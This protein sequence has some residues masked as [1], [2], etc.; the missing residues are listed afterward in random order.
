MFKANITQTPFTTDAANACFP[1]ITGDKFGYDVTF[2]A[3]LRAL[4][5]PRMNDRESIYL[6][7]GSSNHSYSAVRGS[8]DEAVVS[9]ICGGYRLNSPGQLVIHSIKGAHGQREVEENKKDIEANFKSIESGFTSAYRGYHRSDGL[10]AFYRKSFLVDCYINPELKS[11]I[12]FVENLDN[13]K[14]H[15]LQVSI[16]AMLSWYLDPKAGLSKDE[17]ELVYSL[18]ETTP[19]KYNQCLAKMA[20]NYDFRTAKIRQMLSD[21]ETKYEKAECEKVK[22]EIESYDNHIRD[23]NH[24]I[25]D[26]LRQ[27]NESCIRLMGLQ[28][29]IAQGGDS[30][31]MEYF[32]C[33]RHLVPER[34]TTSDMFFAVKD[35]LEYF[36]S[37]MAES[38]IENE[39]SFVY[40]YGLASTSEEGAK[41]AERLMKEIFVSD[42]PRLRIRFCAAYQFGLN[43]SVEA[44]RD[45]GFGIEFD[46]YMPNPHINRYRCLGGY[47]QHINEMLR[48]R[49]YIAAIEQC[50]ASCKS[51]NWSDST[52]M[53]TFMSNFWDGARCIEL[54]DGSVV[55]AEQAIQWLEEQDKLAEEAKKNGGT[56]EKEEQTNEPAD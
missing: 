22:R 37:D 5:A 49:D 40:Y 41:K 8:R 24:S 50:I 14:M 10:K 51:L 35:Y 55:K 39:H 33:N 11:S 53:E 2:L 44:I 48:K 27:K 34:V 25:G 23:L 9:A 52:V 30:E 17:M 1:N 43:G 7:F 38:I 54:P 26:Y 36:D 42:N 20:E 46:G 12:V 13:K 19:E 15:Y 28:A 21:F 56:E 45:Y 16:L 31:I 32:L 29:K 3:T 47:S 6:K 18:R 4:L